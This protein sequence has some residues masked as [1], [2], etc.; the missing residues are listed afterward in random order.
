MSTN[1]CPK[2]GKIKKFNYCIF[3]GYMD[4]GNMIDPNKPKEPL[5]IE[6]YLGERYEKINRNTNAF[7]L[8]ILGPFYFFYNKF[9]LI[10]LLLI[11]IDYLACSLLCLLFTSVFIRPIFIFILWRILYSTVG[12]MLYLELC[13]FRI[14]KIK[15]KYPDT[16]KEVLLKES[17]KTTSPII[18]LVTILLVIV[19]IIYF[20]I[21]KG[22]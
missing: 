8:F 9:P 3:C 4:N 11:L 5:D 20:L 7:S 18:V 19:G 17:D 16:Y 15:N 22:S 14:K 2:C 6:I 12:N 10:G 13:K 1:R 21:K